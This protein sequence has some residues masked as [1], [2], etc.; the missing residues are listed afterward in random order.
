MGKGMRVVLAVLIIISLVSVAGGIRSFLAEREAFAK[1]LKV[2]ETLEKEKVRLGKRLA[3]A[4]GEKERVRSELDLMTHR[5][6]ELEAENRALVEAKDNLATQLVELKE[7]ARAMESGQFL[8]D[9]LKE[10]ASLEVEARMLKEKLRSQ[11]AQM[12]RL[13]R[14]S[15]ELKAELE[16]KRI[17]GRVAETLSRDL[18]KAK[19]DKFIAI[20][21]LGKFEAENRALQGRF[22][23]LAEAKALLEEGLL[24]AD[25]R[26]RRIEAERDRLAEEVVTVR[27]AL[28]Q[29]EKEIDQAKARLKK[30]IKVAR[31]GVAEG[32]AASIE[33]PPIVVKAEPA[34]AGKKP[35]ISPQGRIVKVNDDYKFVVID[36]GWEDGVKVGMS[37]TVYRGDK[38][39]GRV[40]VIEAHKSVSAADIRLV[41]ERANIRVDDVIVP[42]K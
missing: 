22:A 35:S 10:R 15:E 12:E 39:I 3:R 41:K 30:Q 9:L 1:Y 37:F 20:E 4:E 18:A 42:T 8:S 34:P 36:L 31:K 23:K 24:V 5:H 11:E 32:R 2:K 21:S 27:F 25:D 29:R 16:K 33:L 26:L 28:K 14:T 19:R 6:S 7:K 13:A 17:E 38:K 40:E